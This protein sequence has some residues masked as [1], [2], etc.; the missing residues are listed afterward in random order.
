MKKLII[1]MFALAML[2]TLTACGGKA[3]ENN[4]PAVNDTETQSVVTEAV[5]PEQTQP[6]MNKTDVTLE[7][8]MAAAPTPAEQ[9][10]FMG[11]SETEFWVDAYTGTDNM[12][13]I[14]A[15]HEGAPVT[16]VTHYTF[17][18][19]SSVEAIRFNDTTETVEEMICTNNEV[20][21]IVVLGSGTRQIGESAFQDCDSLEIVILNDGLLEIGPMAFMYCENLKEVTIPATVTNIDATAFY[22]CHNE[23]T[24]YGEAGSYAEVYA[25]ENGIPFV[26]E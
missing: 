8:L 2:L 25:S 23:F 3:D 6:Q 15:K 1:M 5:Q 4:A 7:A 12:V 20:L 11:S 26:A 24:I 13:V 17:S 10:V 22:V 9:F 18:G 14:P 16:S 19:D 21:K